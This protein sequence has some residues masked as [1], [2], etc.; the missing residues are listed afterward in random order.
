MGF[1][2]PFL[3]ADLGNFF[4]GGLSS[5]LIARGWRVGDARKVIA[6]IGD[7]WDDVPD[8]DGL[9]RFVRRHRELLRHRD[10][11]LRGVFDDHPQPSRRSLSVG[12]G[13][14]G[15]RHGRNR[16]RARDDRR[17]LSH[18]MGGRPLLVRADP[19]GASLVPLVRSPRCC[20]WSATPRRRARASCT[21]SE[22][23]TAASRSEEHPFHHPVTPGRRHQQRTGWH[24]AM[25]EDGRAFTTESRAT[26]GSRPSSA[27]SRRRH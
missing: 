12:L 19:L 13:G 17:H 24:E 3:A 25:A 8:P 7:R 20:S 9:G 10:V 26:A 27:R 22:R 11:R 2:V 15:Q 18:R 4:G 6:V 16:R 21:K 14:V 23:G 5:H 1:W